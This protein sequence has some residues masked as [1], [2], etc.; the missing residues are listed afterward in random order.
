MIAVLDTNKQPLAP[1]TS[2]R[3]RL[4]LKKGKAAVFR[5]YPF[6]IIL[7]RE[8]VN[9][10]LPDL[11]LK[12]DP[13]SKTTGMAIVNQAT[14]DVVFAAEITHRGQAIKA[15]LDSRRVL[16]RSRR[17]RK[18][19]YRQSRFLNCVKPVGWLPPS[20]V[21]RIAN[22]ETWVRR[23]SNAYPVA[24][25][26]MELVRFDM[27]LMENPNIR[28]VEYQQGELAGFEVKEYLLL[29]FNHRCVYARAGSPCNEYLEIEHIHPR[30]R[31]GSNRISNLAIACQKHN[32]EKGN[33]T[34]EEYG[35]PQVQSQVKRPLKDAAAVNTTRRALLNALRFQ[36]FEVE[37]GSG[38]LT[39][40]NRVQRGLEK[41]HWIDAACVGESTPV[42]INVDGVKP[43][44]IKAMGYGNRQMCQTDRFG[45]PIRHRTHNK[46]FLGF[47]TGD[48][49]IANAPNGKAAGR[50]VGRVTIRQRP[51]FKLDGF[52]IHPKYLKRVH[53]NDGYS[54]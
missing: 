31:G 14:G 42:T 13:G 16:R 24:G 17:S 53:R 49:V 7:K 33:R 22:V 27:Q 2:R 26:A 44:K 43:L 8:V 47:Q 20:L 21:S 45:F 40:F 10:T 9:P 32:Q 36:G 4:L 35:F 28:G 37:T 29:K 50:R 6:T 30:S 54:Y 51:A 34:A 5:R 38:G 15:A 3:A 52:S 23:L 1:T 18:T 19:R 39:R 11:K 41:K 48:I 25:L 12:I 46:S